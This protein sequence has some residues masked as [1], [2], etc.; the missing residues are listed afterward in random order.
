MKKFYRNAHW[1]SGSAA[2]CGCRDHSPWRRSPRT[3]DSTWTQ[4]QLEAAFNWQMVKYDG[5]L[6][7]HNTAYAVALLKASIADLKAK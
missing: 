1:P 4:R 7:I 6:G 3:I 5:N 2:G